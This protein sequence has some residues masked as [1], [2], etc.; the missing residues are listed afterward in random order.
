MNKLSSVV[1]FCCL[2]CSAAKAQITPFPGSQPTE[3]DTL[4]SGNT[5]HYTHY[6]YFSITPLTGIGMTIPVHTSSSGMNLA[7]PYTSTNEITDAVNNNASFQANSGIIVSDKVQPYW[8]LFGLEMGG[9]GHFYALDG[10]IGNNLNISAG[11]G[12]F[13]Y[14]NSPG[15]QWKNSVNK[16][17]VFKT[18]VNIAYEEG[19]GRTLLGTID[20]T[21]K[22]IHLLGHTASPTF[23]L[24]TAVDNGDGTTSSETDTYPARNLNVSYSQTEWLLIPKIGI[25]NN[26]YRSSVSNN[27]N[28]PVVHKNVK[29]LWE[30]SL[31]YKIPFA[32]RGGIQLSQND[33]NGN[34]SNL[35]T[36]LISLKTPGVVFMHNGKPTT[37][38][39]FHFSELFISLSF[40]IGSSQYY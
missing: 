24:T 11:Y 36:S 22:T 7:F 23:E 25:G 18:S 10:S 20:N 32:N 15:E 39:F 3:E 40:S 29:I 26:P 27:V 9:L 30:L 31:G 35:N 21:D 2:L 34:S 33:G 28:D 19:D 8:I 38:A 4:N 13:W 14:F 6:R 17:F 5:F 37:S 12:W 16:R 1:V